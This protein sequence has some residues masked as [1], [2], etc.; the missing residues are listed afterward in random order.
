VAIG[1]YFKPELSPI[2][3]VSIRERN[4]RALAVRRYAE[5]IGVPVIVDPALARRLYRTHQR[6]DMVSMEEIHQVVRLLL[7]L[8]QVEIAGTDLPQ[9]DQAENN[10]VENSKTEP[11]AS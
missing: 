9:S 1:I 11:G 7:W 3:F 4:Q 6:Y 5:K 10:T 8:Q 2:P